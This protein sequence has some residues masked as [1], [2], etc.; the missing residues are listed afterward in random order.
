MNGL[1]QF[2]QDVASGRVDAVL[3]TRIRVRGDMT[4]LTFYR[5]DD[6]TLLG[7]AEV[8][9]RRFSYQITESLKSALAEQYRRRPVEPFFKPGKRK[10]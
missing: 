4:H 5:P 1:L 6:Q 7:V 9:S 10:R 3:D 2:W 8:D